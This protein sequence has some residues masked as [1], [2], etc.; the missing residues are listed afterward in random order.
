[1]PKMLRLNRFGIGPNSESYEPLPQRT[2]GVEIKSSNHETS[3]LLATLINISRIN[4]SKA[5]PFLSTIRLCFF[6]F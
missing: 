3:I 2:T 5:T 4:I 1:M 6:G